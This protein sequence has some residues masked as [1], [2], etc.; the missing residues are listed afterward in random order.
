MKI[1]KAFKYRIYPNKSQVN[2]IEKNFAGC[3][4][5]FNCLL[6]ETKKERED[7]PDV[8]QNLSAFGFG[9]KVTDMKSEDDKKW[10]CECDSIALIYEAENLANGFKV[11]FRNLKSNPADA[12]YP[13][14]KSKY[15]S[16]QSY[17]TRNV[18]IE[19]GKLNLP[20]M[21]CLVKMKYH[22]VY[23]GKIKQATIS[24]KN[25]KYYVSLMVEMEID[26]VVHPVKKT[27]GLDFGV[28][29]FAT[30]SDGKSIK[31]P[32]FLIEQSKYLAILQ[33]KLSRAVKGSN[34]HKKLKHKIA[35]L[36][37]RV[38]NKRTHFHYEVVKDLLNDYDKIYIQNL[39]TKKMT[40]K[41]DL[42]FEG[43][44]KNKLN[45]KV[46]DAAPANFH[47]KLMH[48]ADWQGKQVEKIEKFEPTTATCGF[49]SHV[50]L[51]PQLKAN[52]WNCEKCGCEN[53]RDFNGAKNILKAGELIK[54]GDVTSELI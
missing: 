7:N 49:C 28:Q 41:K 42:N 53:K 46:L 31:N 1:N 35:C 45:R 23:E 20:K 4:V 16:K 37:E 11:F 3:R 38:T 9:Y 8:K 36:H 18:R 27:I 40:K 52:K 30:T 13:R 43:F 5:V 15:D 47:T 2:Y 6:Y 24:R 48:K 17:R 44:N 26:R 32:S 22:R 51:K 25:K 39:S 54:S 33:Q 14:F 50:N 34:N 12:G 29:D 21:K 10:L 19:D